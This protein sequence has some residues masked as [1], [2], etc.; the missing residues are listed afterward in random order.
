MKERH[1][2]ANQS[3]NGTNQGKP[4]RLRWLFPFFLI[5]FNSVIAGVLLLLRMM[6]GFQIQQGYLPLITLVSLLS[7]ISLGT[8]LFARKKKLLLL[9]KGHRNILTLALIL[10][11]FVGMLATL[12]AEGLQLIGGLILSTVY[13]V[14]FVA[15][16][17][18]LER[19]HAKCL[20]A[21]IY[22]D[23]IQLRVRRTEPV[24]REVISNEEPETPEEDNEALFK[25][26]IQQGD[27]ALETGEN[28]SKENYSQWMNRTTD[29]D[30]FEV[31][32]GG[33]LV[34]FSANQKMS[35]VHVGLVPPLDGD[36]DVRCETEDD[37]V[38]RTRVLETRGY[39][40]SVQVNRTHDLDSNFETYLYYR[41]T[42]RTLREAVA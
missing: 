29:P 35:I 7:C 13:F 17:E 14:G 23:V 11:V 2:S 42:N 24:A 16:L 21:H 31:I 9:A 40:I 8:L 30:G 27:C 15:V 28:E 26:L 36:L 22:D 18:L 6:G 10:P 38:V 41:I 39:G 1:R 3:N 19:E 33:A 20:E 32:E 25:A 12:P 5:G 4:S 37:T 34:Q